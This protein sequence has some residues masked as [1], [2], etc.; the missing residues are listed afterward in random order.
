MVRGGS[1]LLHD[2]HAAQS[3]LM[4]GRKKGWFE[5]LYCGK[6]EKRVALRV[7]DRSSMTAVLQRSGRRGAKFVRAHGLTLQSSECARS[8]MQTGI[9]VEYLH[10]AW[11]QL[12]PF[13]NDRNIS[14]HVKV[15]GL[16]LFVIWK[17][18][19]MN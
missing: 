13:Q 12:C 3:V 7:H 18:G 6:T 14:A 17:Q 10:Q 2:L 15:T 8:R 19:R 5:G 1:G 9:I 4:R 11:L 16:E